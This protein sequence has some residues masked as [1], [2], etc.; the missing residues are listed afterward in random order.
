MFGV[1]NSNVVVTVLDVHYRFL[2]W[3]VK[4]RS[5]DLVLEAFENIARIQYFFE[6]L[7]FIFFIVLNYLVGPS[8]VLQIDNVLVGEYRVVL[9]DYRYIEDGEYTAFGQQFDNN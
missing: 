6:K 9:T 3:S 8:V 7:F 5:F 4:M 2:N 1:E